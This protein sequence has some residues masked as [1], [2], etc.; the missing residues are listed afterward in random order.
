MG[1]KA[2]VKVEL[3]ELKASCFIIMPFSSTYGTLYERVIRPAVEEAGLTCVRA[4]EVFTKAQVSHEIWK[5]IRECR[6]LIAELTGKNP[7]CLNNL[8]LK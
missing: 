7:K 4:D 2:N 3:G 1:K 8:A 5:Q 6:L